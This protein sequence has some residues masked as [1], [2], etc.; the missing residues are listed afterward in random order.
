MQRICIK[1]QNISLPHP[2]R[3]LL[4]EAPM[5]RVVPELQGTP[6]LHVRHLGQDHLED[7]LLKGPAKEGAKAETKAKAGLAETKAKAGLPPP[8]D[9]IVAKTLPEIKKEFATSSRTRAS[10]VKDLRV[11]TPMIKTR[12]A[13]PIG[14]LRRPQ[15]H[16]G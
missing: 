9:P 3:D 10:A 15:G 2:L 5:L 14:D 7:P 12:E 8:V 11:I 16:K 13:K 6:D 4:R 1:D